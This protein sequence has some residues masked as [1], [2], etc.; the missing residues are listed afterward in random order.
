MDKRR[1]M[2]DKSALA[3]LTPEEKQLWSGAA[4]SQARE[5]GL[6][7]EQ[8]EAQRREV[9]EAQNEAWP[10]VRPQAPVSTPYRPPAPTPAPAP[11]P[12]ATTQAG[13]ASDMGCFGD[14][15]AI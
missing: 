13:P 9:R 10:A 11:A 4:E 3:I 6:T 14:E 1:A 12:P 15:E 7:G 8:Q 5:R 2:T